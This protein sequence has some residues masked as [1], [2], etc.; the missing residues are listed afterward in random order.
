MSL[1]R[2]LAAAAAVIALTT[3]NLKPLLTH[4]LSLLITIKRARKNKKRP[5]RLEIIREGIVITI[6]TLIKVVITL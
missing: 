6:T 3:L 5:A 1:A 2:Y 4:L